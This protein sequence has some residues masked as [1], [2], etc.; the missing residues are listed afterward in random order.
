MVYYF[1]AKF[2][3]LK[4]NNVITDCAQLIV[5]RAKFKYF[6]RKYLSRLKGNL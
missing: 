6:P 1:V 5:T 3:Q 2:V 4:S